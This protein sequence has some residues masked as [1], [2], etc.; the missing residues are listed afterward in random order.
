MEFLVKFLLE[1]LFGDIPT[2]TKRFVH[3]QKV[4]SI[5]TILQQHESSPVIASW[6]ASVYLFNLEPYNILAAGDFLL[7]SF[8]A[9]W[10]LAH[11]K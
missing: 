9:P 11:L 8:R 5:T 7:P 3:L 1:F 10:A 4:D 6:Q 2:P